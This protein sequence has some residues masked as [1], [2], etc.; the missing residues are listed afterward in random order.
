MFE[1]CFK[2]ICYSNLSAQCAFMG[3]FF[4]SHYHTVFLYPSLQQFIVPFSLSFFLVLIVSS[5]EKRDSEGSVLI[6]ACS[7]LFCPQTGGCNCFLY[8][9]AKQYTHTHILEYFDLV[10]TLLLCTQPVRSPLS[11]LLM[12]GSSMYTLMCLKVEY[13]LSNYEQPV[14]HTL[15]FKTLWRRWDYTSTLNVIRWKTEMSVSPCLND[16]GDQQL[17]CEVEQ[18]GIVDCRFILELLLSSFHGICSCSPDC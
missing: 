10:P 12:G 18:A 5:R 3:V 15:L 2:L 7:F 9:A 8:W 1:A 4:T 13:F 11:L 17:D 6:F 16:S 14:S